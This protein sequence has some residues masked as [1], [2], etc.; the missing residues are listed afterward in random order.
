MEQLDVPGGALAYEMA[1]SGEPVLLIHGGVLA[2]GFVPLTTEPALASNHRL[3]RYHRRGYGRSARATP[4]FSIAQQAADAQALLRHL[5]IRRA[6]VAGHSY[7][8]AIAMQLALDAPGMVGTLA[9][10]EPALVALVS[11]APEFMARIAELETLHRSGDRAG[12][13]DGFLTGVLGPGYRPLI[14]RHLP[15]GAFDLAVEDSDTLF[16]VELGA[17]QQWHLTADDA[18]RIRQPVLAVIGG[19]SEPIF[20][21]VHALLKQ[22]LPHLEELAVPGVTHALQTMAPE[23]IAEGLAAFFAAH[24]L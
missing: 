22:W 9:L 4:P 14:E 1:G 11:S 16:A 21:D 8:G 2:D 20:H 3:V 23:P 10:L 6:H 12:T 13:I 19:T 18:A 7:G 24:P 5:G 17:L 15:S